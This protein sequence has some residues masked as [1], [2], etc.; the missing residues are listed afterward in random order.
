MDPRLGR[1]QS[2]RRPAICLSPT[3][4][5]RKSGLALFCPITSQ[6]KGYPF[7]VPVSGV[8]AIKGVAL[9]DQLKSFDWDKRKFKKIGKC[10]AD[11]IERILIRATQLLKI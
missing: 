9:S 11:Q 6:V 2:G 7:E 10:G 4:Y 1:K 5:N 3:K 8:K